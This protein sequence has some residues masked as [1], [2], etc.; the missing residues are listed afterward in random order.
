MFTTCL[1]TLHPV[2]TFDMTAKRKGHHGPITFSDQSLN[3][4]SARVAWYHEHVASIPDA[5]RKLLEKYSGIPPNQVLSHVLEIRDRAFAIWS[6]ACM[7]QVR[8]LSYTL[9]LHVYYAPTLELLRSG[10]NFLDAGCCFGQEI[11]FLAHVDKIPA[12]QLYGFDLE[13]GFIDMGHDLFRDKDELGATCCLVIFWQISGRQRLSSLIP[14]GGKMDVVHAASVL[15]CWDWDD[16]IRATKRLVSL[17]RPE[18]GS[19]IVGNQMGSL[20]AGRYDMPTVKGYNYR[21]NVESM[22]RFWK[23]VEEESRTRWKVESGLYLPA[24]VKESQEH[25]WAKSDP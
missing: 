9:P 19:L 25:S 20:N 21:H 3:N 10:G 4:S 12:K 14:S 8:F 1:F 5:G 17:T 15:H 13:P 6:Y 16:M 23:Q 2:Q 22:E 7:G 11:R 24:V 18:P